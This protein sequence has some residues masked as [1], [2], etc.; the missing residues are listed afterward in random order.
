MTSL[1]D[2][3]ASG[4]LLCF[5]RF[6][7][8]RILALCYNL[9]GISFYRNPSFLQGGSVQVL[10]DIIGNMITTIRYGDDN[11]TFRL[12]RSFRGS[13]SDLYLFDNISS[14][15]G[16]F[17]NI[18]IR[19]N[20]NRRAILSLQNQDERNY[21]GRIYARVRNVRL[22]SVVTN[23]LRT[24]RIIRPGRIKAPLPAF[25]INGRQYVDNR[26]CSIYITFRN[27]RRNNFMS[28]YSNIIP[29]RTIT[30]IITNM[31]TNGGLQTFA[32]MIIMTIR[33]IL[34]PI[35]QA[36]RIFIRRIC[37]LFLRIFPT[38]VR[39]FAFEIEAK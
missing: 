2:T 21:K 28:E 7:S 10:C 13:I 8:C 5:L 37:L 20:A 6:R 24:I 27:H 19:C 34:R 31:F 39:R 38:S 1:G 14:F 25:G 3:I 11:L 4:Q 15:G 30:I 18:F 23:N 33:T 29:L 17:I 32:I 35:C 36:M 12:L 9:R 22:L 26:I 16:V